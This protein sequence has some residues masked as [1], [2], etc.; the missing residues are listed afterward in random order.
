MDVGGKE[1]PYGLQS[2]VNNTH[3]NTAAAAAL[4]SRG[5]L[6]VFITFLLP[7]FLSPDPLKIYSA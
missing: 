5:L 2:N 4:A 6:A 7:F 3:T 1:E